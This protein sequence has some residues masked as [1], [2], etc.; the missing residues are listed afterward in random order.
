MKLTNIPSWSATNSARIVNN[1]NKTSVGFTP[2][3]PYP[4][5]EYD[6]IYT[7]MKN[8][9]DVLHQTFNQ[10]GALWCDEGVYR[11]AKELQ[12][13]FPET[14][15]NIF[16]GLGGFHMEKTIIACIGKYHQGSGVDSIFTNNR[17]FGSGVVINVLDG[18]H[19]TRGIRGLSIYAEVMQRL[20]LMSF[21]EHHT[22]DKYPD[23]LK[24]I[25][26]LQDQLQ[27]DINHHEINQTFENAMVPLHQF[28]SDLKEFEKLGS[29][30]SV[31]F[32]YWNNFT[33]DIYPI[34]R[35]NLT[36]SI[37]N[38]EWT[39]YITTL[40]EALPL[41]FAFDITNYSR[42][43]SLYYEDCLSLKDKFPTIYNE[44][45]KGN[46]VVN[47]TSRKGSSVPMDQA[48][49]KS[50]NKP[51]KGKSGIIGITRRK[52]AVAQYDIIKHEKLQLVNYL[53]E[54]CEINYD[55]EYDLHHESSPAITE[56]DEMMVNHMTNYIFERRNPF[57]LQET[58]ELKNLVTEKHFTEQEI[59]FSFECLTIGSKAYTD[60]VEDRL[61]KKSKKLFDTLSRNWK[62]P[63]KP[64]D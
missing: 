18:G 51:A 5:T 20:K 32:R 52:E 6:T 15:D 34:L 22:I 42:W 12:L 1:V 14:F 64:V 3:L 31:I 21:F 58:K 24:H 13:L 33:E 54:F 2:L 25:K 38:G 10:C 44:F 17:V 27:G 23:L 53:L 43:G 35:N 26:S 60:F 50:Y 57:I 16:L 4:A 40:R 7:C 48:L 61:N 39:L 63:K 19:Y 29:Q 30:M 9:Q 41:L 47:F 11:L 49:E 8:F 59:N 45:V 56:K 55:S 28:T 36:T 46:F 62:R 37:R